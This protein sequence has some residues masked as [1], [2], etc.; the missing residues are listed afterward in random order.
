M[1]AMPDR[2]AVR[3]AR[4]RPSGP[5]VTGARNRWN[6]STSP[7]SRKLRATLAP[8]STI[9]RLMPRSAKVGQHL[10]AR[11]PRSTSAPRRA[12]R[13]SGGRLPCCGSCT[14]GLGERCVQ[15]RQAAGRVP[16]RPPAPCPC[17]RGWRR[18]GRAA[19]GRGPCA[20]DRRWRC[21]CRPRRRSCHRRKRPSSES[22][23]GA[24]C[25]FESGSPPCRAGPHRRPRPDSQAMPARSRMAWPPPET[26]GSGSSMAVTTRAMPAATS[27]SAQGPVR[28]MMRAGLERD[29]GG[30][31]AGRLARHLQRLGLGMGPAAGLGPAHAEEASILDDHAADIGVLRRGARAPGGRAAALGP[32]SGDR[33]LSPVSPLSSSPESSPK[34][35]SK[36]LASRKFL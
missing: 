33:Q 29:I 17:R 23:A 35:S 24:S 12:R 5:S 15:A 7:A 31:A 9:R 28:A 4:P 14:K 20:S 26:R 25:E 8:P 10:R 13:E 16:G 27:A 1:A 2:A 32:S 30:G 19:G 11:V 6:S 18:T 22:L 34:S 36:S 3:P 21:A